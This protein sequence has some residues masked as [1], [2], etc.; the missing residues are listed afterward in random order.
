MFYKV[1]IKLRLSFFIFL[2]VGVFLKA[3]SAELSD[4]H[5]LFISEMFV[6]I[7][8]RASSG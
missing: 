1:Q 8:S 6:K 4:M 2:A 3:H 5:L 7:I